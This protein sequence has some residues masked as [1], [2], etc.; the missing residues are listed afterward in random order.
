MATK[1]KPQPQKSIL[2]LASY[3]KSGNTWLRIFLAN[4]LFNLDRPVP[5]NE[6]HRIGMGDSVANAYRKVAKGEFDVHDVRQTLR[7]RNAV[8]QAVV[9]NGAEV[10]FLK[11]HNK[12]GAI[13]EVE[14]IPRKFTRGAI[15]VMRDPRDMVF[16]YARHFGYDVDGASQAI[17]AP[18]NGAVP[19]KSVVTQWFGS[20]SDH[21]RSWTRGKGFPLLTLR[22][23]DMQSNP[24][25]AF[26]RVLKFIGMPVD[27]ARLEKAI[28]FS[29]FDE[30]RKQE[31]EKGFIEKSAVAERFFHSGTSGQ[32]RNDLPPALADRIVVA[33][34]ET[35]REFGYI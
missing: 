7:L 22:Y 24:T 9:N 17:C 3:P 19:D 29:S 32:W 30:V 28:R 14:L 21:V 26:G 35:M 4:Y 11:T 5:I 18:M 25:L 33:N 16:S 13:N 10:N 1:P 31:S 8:L 15:Y 34:G 2:W 20:W 6:V 27:A 12:R 23:E